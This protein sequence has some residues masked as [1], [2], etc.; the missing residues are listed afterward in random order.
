MRGDKETTNWLNKS[1]MKQ[2]RQKKLSI[3]AVGVLSTVAV[4]VGYLLYLY[5]GQRNPSIRDVKPKSKC[6]VLTQDLFDKIENWQEELSKDSVILVLP[7]VA[8]LGN[9]LKLQLSSIEHKIVI[10]NN[11]SAVWSAVRHLKKY[12]LV[13]SRDKTSDMPVDLR[14]YVGQISH[15]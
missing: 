2:A 1:L 10:F 6:Y 8:H 4:T 11:S 15:I 14:R 13:I 9:H 7:E 3:I 12:E 5:R